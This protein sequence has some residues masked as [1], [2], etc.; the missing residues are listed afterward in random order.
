MV[1]IQCFW[2]LFWLTYN[3]FSS[4]PTNNEGG[5]YF[6]SAITKCRIEVKYLN[7]TQLEIIAIRWT[8]ISGTEQHGGFEF[9]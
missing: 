9:D 8:G 6:L 3:T 5:S 2:V 7:R 4:V 1:L